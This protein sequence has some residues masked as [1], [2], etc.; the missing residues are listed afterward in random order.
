MDHW[1]CNIAVTRLVAHPIDIIGPASV[2][3]VRL[4]RSIIML[5]TNSVL[6]I[7]TQSR[8]LPFFCFFCNTVHAIP[9]FIIPNTVDSLSLIWSTLA[10]RIPRVN[11]PWKMYCFPHSDSPIDAN[12]KC[13]IRKKYF[14][15]RLKIVLGVVTLLGSYLKGVCLPCTIRSINSQCCTNETEAGF[16]IFLWQI[17]SAPWWYV[18]SFKGYFHRQDEILVIPFQWFAWDCFPSD[19]MQ[20][21]SVHATQWFSE[22]PIANRAWISN[23]MQRFTW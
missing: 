22:I 5:N 18:Q 23:Y 6:V 21:A 3:G 10:C 13:Q 8:Y 17:N 4:Q 2:H 19:E 14:S 11:A 7:Y 9:L 20:Q 15:F 1:N 16:T 12:V